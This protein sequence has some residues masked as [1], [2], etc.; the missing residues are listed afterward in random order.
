MSTLAQLNIEGKIIV[1][2]KEIDTNLNHFF[3]NI[4][5]NTEAN[6]PKVKNISPGKFLRNRVI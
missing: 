6:T 3:T 5:P 4:G 1:N 2:H